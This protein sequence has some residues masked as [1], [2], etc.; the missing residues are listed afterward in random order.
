MYLGVGDLGKLSAVTEGSDVQ[1][2]GMQ[3]SLSAIDSNLLGECMNDIQL[4]APVSILFAV[5]DDTGN[6]IGVPYPLFVGVVDQP[7]VQLG[8]KEMSISLSLE[9]RL[10]DL[11]R[12]NQ[13]KYTS[14]DQMLY[15]PTDCSFFAN[16]LLNDQ[17][18]VW[19]A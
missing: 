14:G 7:K 1:A 3:I 4:G 8:T 10:L 19:K 15:Y 17:C 18:L 6:I 5:L 16:E 2:Y 12:A 11:Q 13:R 9:N